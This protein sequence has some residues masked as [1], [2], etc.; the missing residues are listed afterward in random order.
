MFPDMDLRSIAAVALSASCVYDASHPCGANMHFDDT[1][2]ACLCDDGAISVD[3]GCQLCADD[4]VV[5]DN[6]C[7]CP[8]GTTKDAANICTAVPGLGDPCDAAKPCID[9]TYSYCAIHDGAAAGTCTKQCAS[10]ADCIDTYTCATWLAQPYC[11][12]FAGLG[13]PCSAQEDCAGTDATFCDTFISHTCV[14]A[15]CTLTGNECPRGTTCCDLSNFGF[16]NL[17]GQSCPS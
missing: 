1:L 13:K 12:V 14:V 4:E 7:A 17:C 6:T 11:M 10:N 3:G 8:P 9:A 15:N 5:A 2:E 16:E